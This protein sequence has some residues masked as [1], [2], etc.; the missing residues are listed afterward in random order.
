[1]RPDTVWLPPA[2]CGL[3]AG[4]PRRGLT[5]STATGPSPMW[6]PAKLSRRKLCVL[7]R[8]RAKAMYPDLDRRCKQASRQAGRQA[9]VVR[10]RP[11]CTARR[12]LPWPCNRPHAHHAQLQLANLRVRQDVL[13]R[14]VE[15]EPHTARQRSSVAREES[16]GAVA[17]AVDRAQIRL[18]RGRSQLVLHV[19][20]GDAHAVLVRLGRERRGT[21]RH[22]CVV[23]VVLGVRRLRAVPA[24]A[25][26]HA[27]RRR[28]GPH[29]V[30]Q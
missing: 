6:L 8:P 19:R 25:S 1:M 4:K 21:L 15:L 22:V 9:G 27:D 5:C 28:G 11:L 13:K 30:K 29:A 2:R 12:A 18:L 20:R 26:R 14:R 10:V 3:S 16:D 24:V 17:R 23:L 7:A